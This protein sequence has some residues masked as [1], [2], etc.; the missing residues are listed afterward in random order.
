MCPSGKFG[1]AWCE[2]C[3]DRI[4]GVKWDRSLRERYKSIR[5]TTSTPLR[6]WRGMIVIPAFFLLVILAVT[7]FGKRHEAQRAANEQQKEALLA[8]PLPGDIYR[9]H[10][11]GQMVKI[12][13]NSAAAS[14]DV[15][16]LYKVVG[17]SGD[18]VFVVA[19]NA[20]RIS[21]AEK[22]INPYT[23]GFWEEIEKETT[24]FNGK[25]IAISHQ[26][27][28]KYGYFS[29]LMK[30]KDDMPGSIMSATRNHDKK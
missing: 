26:S 29:R 19:G 4:L 7:Y 15:Y 6:L 1:I 5:S 14:N 2:R 24:A 17:R 9:A 11:G 3:G 8:A 10:D 20:T 28:V 21:T 25:P 27:M 13:E 22:P 30:S 23:D 12:N 16:A 18:S